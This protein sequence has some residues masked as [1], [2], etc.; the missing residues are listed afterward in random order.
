[1]TVRGYK[2][3]ERSSGDN[4]HVIKRTLAMKPYQHSPY[5]STARLLFTTTLML[6]AG[7]LAWWGWTH[8]AL[9]GLQFALLGA[10]IVVVA[11]PFILVWFRKNTAA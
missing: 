5:V 11:A 9:G 1:M 10:V 8:V 3:K 4:T 2:L 7:V 6:L